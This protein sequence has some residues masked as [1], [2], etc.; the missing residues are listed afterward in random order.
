VTT[1]AFLDNWYTLPNVVFAFASP[2]MIANRKFPSDT[3][4]VLQ[5]S[6]PVS[7]MV[8]ICFLSMATSMPGS[9]CVWNILSLED[10]NIWWTK[11]LTLLFLPIPAMFTIWA[12]VVSCNHGRVIDIGMILLTLSSVRLLEVIYIPTILS[13]TGMAVLLSVRLY[14]HIYP[15]L[16]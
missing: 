16:D 9:S 15:K 2:L 7:A 11:L 13:C 3:R 10:G 4:Q 8:S 14:S 5:I 1:G 12:V 6:M